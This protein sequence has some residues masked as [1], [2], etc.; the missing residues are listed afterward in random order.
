MNQKMISSSLMV[1]LS[2]EVDFRG[3]PPILIGHKVGPEPLKSP[4]DGTRLP[5][6]FLKNA[7]LSWYML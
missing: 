6:E 1:S 3:L 2:E 4:P 7:L 5:G